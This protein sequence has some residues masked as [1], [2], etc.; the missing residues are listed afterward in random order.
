MTKKPYLAGQPPA[1]PSG[2]N[3]LSKYKSLALSGFVVIYGFIFWHNQ[4]L[5]KF[6]AR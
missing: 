6:V 4:I 1:P 5:S 3:S 2:G